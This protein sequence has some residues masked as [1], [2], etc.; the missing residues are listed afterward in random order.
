MLGALTG[1]S[2]PITKNNNK[3][4][5]DPSRTDRR[6]DRSPAIRNFVTVARRAAQGRIDSHRGE[7]SVTSAAEVPHGQV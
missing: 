7:R 6:N 3:E 4:A 2:C 5:R 1:R